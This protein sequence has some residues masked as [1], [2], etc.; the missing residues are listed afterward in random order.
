MVHCLVKS[1]EQSP[2]CPASVRECFD[3]F[4]IGPWILTELAHETLDL[5]NGENWLKIGQE[6][7]PNIIIIWKVLGQFRYDF[8]LCVL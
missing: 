7:R 6:L 1:L 3:Y 2:N 8:D 5:S 4:Q